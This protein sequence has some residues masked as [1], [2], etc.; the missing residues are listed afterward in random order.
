[1]IIGIDGNE[2][3]IRNRVGINT[4][5]HELLINLAKL[6]D[7][8]RSEHTIIVYLKEKPLGDMPEETA[9]FKYNVIPG[10]NLWILL[11]L[12]P[13]LLSNNEKPDVFLT[14]S[15]YVPFFLPIPKVCSIMDLGYLE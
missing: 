6:Q 1:M 7:N 13:Y 11:K 10:Q 2:A 8:F 9:N 14:P 15:H 12:T 4:Y 5:A 3:N